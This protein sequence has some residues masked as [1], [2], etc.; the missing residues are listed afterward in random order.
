MFLAIYTEEVTLQTSLSW[1]N[2]K[3]FVIITHAQKV[4][5]CSLIL[6]KSNIFLVFLILKLEADFQ[7]VVF[8]QILW[9]F[10]NFFWKINN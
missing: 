7:Q 10:D 6:K 9:S 1:F 4:L 2:A 5:F 8:V 3:P